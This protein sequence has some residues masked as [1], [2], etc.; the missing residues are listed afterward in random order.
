MAGPAAAPR[1]AVLGAEGPLGRPIAVALA[2][3]GATVAVLS[4]ST[5]QQADFAV[6]SV[7]NEIWAIGRAGGAA[8]ADGSDPASVTAALRRTASAV[9]GLDALVTHLVWEGGPD[10]AGAVAALGSW[11]H[12]EKAI[13]HVL[14]PAHRADPAQADALLQSARR[15]AEQADDSRVNV[16]VVDGALAEQAPAAEQ[17]AEAPDAASA[18]VYLLLGGGVVCRGRV[19]VTAP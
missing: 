10:A 5:G 13:V 11:R 16:V 2:E 15:S 8:V 1:V 3:A 12:P 7:E 18:V 4:I 17:L 19:L 14:G 9:G 6:H